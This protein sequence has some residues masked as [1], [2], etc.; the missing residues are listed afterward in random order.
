VNLVQSETTF[1]PAPPQ[2]RVGVISQETQPVRGTPGHRRGFQVRKAFFGKQNSTHY[3]VTDYDGPFQCVRGPV[4]QPMWQERMAGNL[5]LD[6]LTK[7]F[8]TTAT[9][10]K[11]FTLARRDS[12]ALLTLRRPSMAGFRCKR[13]CSQD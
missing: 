11:I 9:F 5:A 1:T 13:R 2:R 10:A 8:C 3:D 12:Y 7:P 4:T 6:A